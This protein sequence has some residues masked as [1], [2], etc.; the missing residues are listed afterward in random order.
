MQVHNQS[1]H[2]VPWHTNGEEVKPEDLLIKDATIQNMTK[3]SLQFGDSRSPA[4]Q[5]NSM[6]QVGNDWQA[7]VQQQASS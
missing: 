3:L 1:Q 5:L 6:P 7:D 4:Q 2:I